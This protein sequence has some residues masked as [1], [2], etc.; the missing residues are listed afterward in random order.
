[1]Q[2]HLQ[3]TMNL[4]LEMPAKREFD[5]AGFGANAID[6][7]VRMSG[8]PSFGGKSEIDSYDIEPGGEVASTMFGLERLGFKTAYA[9][10]FGCD[11]AGE[12]GLRS[13]RDAGVNLEYSR[14][15]E[16]AKTQ[17]GFILIDGSSGERTVLWQR[18]P[19]L[20]HTAADAPIDLVSRCRILHMT[21]HD[22]PAC[23]RM[24]E[25]ARAAGTIVS[26][27]AD[28]VFKGIEEL[29][30]LVDICITSEDLPQR[31]TG[32]T[33]LRTA[34]KRMQD[35]YAPTIIGATL[36]KRGSIFLSGEEYIE[37]PGVPVPG[38][39]IDTTGAGD[40]FR[41]GFLYGVLSGQSIDECCRTANAVASLK[42]RQIGARRG[43]PAIDEVQTMLKNS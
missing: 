8:P 30:P 32:E 42:C 28:N 7:L 41:T 39:C 14:I 26:L 40:A 4:T 34:L 2:T 33:D 9:G 25:A 11:A 43:L 5:A 24:A 16:T 37:T 36:G 22:S 31:L 35:A 18:D 15:V 29:L 19:A 13:L 27:D 17:V 38:G 1:M 10:S 20:A 3:D 21:P 6:H 12:I 23:I